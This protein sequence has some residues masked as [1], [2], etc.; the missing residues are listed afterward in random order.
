MGHL[1]ADEMAGM[2]EGGAISLREALGWHLRYNHYPPL[3]ESLIDVAEKAIE[4]A[5]NADPYAWEVT[6]LDLPE[7]I[8]FRGCTTIAVAEAIESM[9]LEDFLGCEGDSDDETA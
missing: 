9:H 1:Q 7:G 6:L 8:T 4:E 3:P 2:V 5:R